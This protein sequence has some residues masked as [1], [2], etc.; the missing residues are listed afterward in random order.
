MPRRLT[1]LLALA[2]SLIAAAPARAQSL[3][4]LYE[5]ARAY[6]A[7]FLAARA[8]ADSAQYRL[9]QSRALQRPTASLAG[10]LTRAANS[11]TP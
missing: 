2:T 1:L 5:A 6:D 9:E 4:E 11:A 7:T 8:L 10:S 3:Q